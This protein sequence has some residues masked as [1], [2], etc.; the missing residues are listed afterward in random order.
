MLVLVTNW[1]LHLYT[2]FFWTSHWQV[3]IALI[4]GGN[5]LLLL[6]FNFGLVGRVFWYLRAT[7]LLWTLTWGLAVTL[8][9]AVLHPG[10]FARA[11]HALA[12]SGPTVQ[13]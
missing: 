9:L 13:N 11:C 3:M 4:V 5:L 8:V 6:C 7:A 10:G 12:A 1:L 2:D